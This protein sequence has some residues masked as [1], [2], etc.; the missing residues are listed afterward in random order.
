MLN[1]KQ[2]TMKNKI[3]R[4]YIYEKYDTYYGPIGK[5][6]QSGSNRLAGYAYQIT[7]LQFA[8]KLLQNA[9]TIIDVGMNIGMNT[10]EYATMAQRV[11]GFEPTPD[12]Y[13]WACKNIAWNQ[14]NVDYKL[15]HWMDST[16][17]K[18]VAPSQHNKDLCKNIIPYNFA[19]TNKN[20][21]VT[22]TY[23]TNG[24]TKI[25]KADAKKD[26]QDYVVDGKTLDSF[27]F[28]NV[29]YIKVDVEG[30]ELQVLKGACNTI[31]Y[32]RPIIELEIVPKQCKGAGYTATDIWDLLVLGKGHLGAKSGFYSGYKVF[33]KDGFDRTDGIT[34]EG[35]HIHQHGKELKKVGMNYFFIPGETIDR[36]PKIKYILDEAKKIQELVEEKN[37]TKL[38][39]Y[40]LS[41][42]YK[43]TTE[44]YYQDPDVKEKRNEM[45]K[46]KQQTAKWK[47]WRHKYYIK[48]IKTQPKK[49]KWEIKTG[50]TLNGWATEWNISKEGARK[51]LLKEEA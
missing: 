47:E 51:K 4:K 6:G 9:N 48:N 49:S 3:G 29:D 14:K 10:I 44:K 27:Q 24:Q 42:K 46:E 2:A 31:G 15:P 35:G 11:I 50:K 26:S 28:N 5:N 45:Q 43:D 25:K 39:K 18:F 38:Q 12:L 1:L 37:L 32:N 22:L 8:N 13:K 17:R 34:I 33:T 41:D 23:R 19:I 40:R 7:N 21:P 30:F 20:G 36:N 16:N